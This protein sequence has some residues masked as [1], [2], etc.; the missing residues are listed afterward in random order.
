MFDKC[1]LS[2]QR[3]WR[4]HWNLTRHFMLKLLALALTS[5]KHRRMAARKKNA[6]ALHS[7]IHSLHSVVDFNQRT[8][9]GRDLF[10]FIFFIC[11][12]HSFCVPVVHSRWHRH[13]SWCLKNGR[14]GRHQ[15]SR[16]VPAKQ[17]VYCEIGSPLWIQ[18]I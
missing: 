12:L 11:C 10:I 9:Y 5:N 8:K 3:R 7:F 2:W 4:R 17:S 16:Y 18:Y 13:I 14:H 6:L 1:T 15:H